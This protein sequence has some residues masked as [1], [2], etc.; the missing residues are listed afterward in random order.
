ML[1]RIYIYSLLSQVFAIIVSTKPTVKVGIKTSISAFKWAVNV[2][3]CA[4]QL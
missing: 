3:L 1:H 4:H 2:N